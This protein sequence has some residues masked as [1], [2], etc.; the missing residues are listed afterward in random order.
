MREAQVIERW[1]K[2]TNIWFNFSHPP[3]PS[4]AS[5]TH[6]ANIWRVSAHFIRDPSF[7]LFQPQH[8]IANNPFKILLMLRPLSASAHSLIKWKSITWLRKF[9]H[10][11]GKEGETLKIG[12]SNNIEKG[13]FISLDICS[14]SKIFPMAK[15]IMRL[16]IFWFKC[17]S[18]MKTIA[19]MTE[20]SNWIFI[21]ET[22]LLQH[23]PLNLDDI[24]FEMGFFKKIFF[25]GTEIIDFSLK[26]KLISKKS[27]SVTI[28]ERNVDSI[29]WFSISCDVPLRKWEKNIIYFKD[30]L[31]NFI[32][33][34]QNNHKIVKSLKSLKSLGSNFV[35]LLPPSHTS[36]FYV[37]NVTFYSF[38][39]CPFLL[40]SLRTHSL[41]EKR[42][43]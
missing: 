42:G 35:H 31:D 4:P 8:L 41:I 36:T 14:S 33:T 10:V 12:S 26:K 9:S 43:R 23:E 18:E 22:P 21:S 25:F 3:P 2:K 20:K 37:F 30:F 16:K 40:E 39:R 28:S 15:T 38:L 11:I 7:V 27:R 5:L 1:L 32:H 24:R 17:K 6:T 29:L 19:L 13:L 34:W